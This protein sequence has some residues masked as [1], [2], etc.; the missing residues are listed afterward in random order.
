[1]K[2]HKGKFF[3]DVIDDKLDWHG[4][5][6]TMKNSVIIREELKKMMKNVD[7]TLPTFAPEFTK[8]WGEDVSTSKFSIT[9]T[10]K[11][12]EKV[13]TRVSYG[14][15]LKRL[16]EC[17]KF[18][19]IMAMDADV[20]NSTF[21]ETFEKAF[22][23]RFINCFIAEQ[24]M[25]SVALGS[26]KRNKI[27]FCSTFACFF[28]RAYDQIRMSAISFGNVKFMGSHT[29]VHIGEDGPSQMGLEVIIIA[30][31]ININIIGFRHV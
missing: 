27:P 3:T 30:N 7:I 8:T 4:K 23:Q 28:T 6:V 10:Y 24:N 13:S 2:T 31:N 19:H 25:V 12:G 26:S 29:G 21:S 5:P 1:M 9:P 11:L 18:E 22:P 20:K 14:N 15:A 16:G 17:D